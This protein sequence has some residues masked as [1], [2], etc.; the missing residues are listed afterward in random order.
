MNLIIK[1]LLDNSSAL[2]Y[3]SFIVSF[4]VFRYYILFEYLL[5]TV[6]LLQRILIK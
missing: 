2:R 3:F 4:E 5:F 6:L 1:V